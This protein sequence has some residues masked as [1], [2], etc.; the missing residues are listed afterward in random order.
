MLIYFIT[1]NYN[2]KK[3]EE[4]NSVIVLFHLHS[5]F[6]NLKIIQ[7]LRSAHNSRSGFYHEYY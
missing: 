4:E 7:T 3:K 6:K 1:R 5:I 2:I